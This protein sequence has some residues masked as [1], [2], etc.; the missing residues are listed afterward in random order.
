MQF[1]L[2]FRPSKSSY[3]RRPLRR[4]RA[5]VAMRDQASRAGGHRSGSVHCLTPTHRIVNAEA[6]A[7]MIEEDEFLNRTWIG[8]AVLGQFQADLGETARFARQVQTEAVSL[9][10]LRPRE[11]VDDRRCEEREEREQ[12]RQ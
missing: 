5:A 8:L 1:C 6:R 2:L 7:G 4:M 9:D 11:R 3:L 12:R 10:F